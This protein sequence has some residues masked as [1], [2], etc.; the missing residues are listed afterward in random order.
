MRR[1]LLKENISMEYRWEVWP[2]QEC[3]WR[4]PPSVLNVDS[5]EVHVWRIHLDLPTMQ[6][7]QMEQMLSSDEKLR[8]D[9]FQFKW[10]RRRYIASH[11]ALRRILSR[12]LRSEPDQLKFAYS[13]LGK[14]ALASNGNAKPLCFNLSHSNEIALC[15]VTFNRSIGIDLEYVRPNLDADSMAKSFFSPH[16]YV[17]ISSFHPDYRHEA[18]FDLWTLKEAYLKAT[19]KGIG[20]LEKVEFSMFSG[21]VPIPNINKE[22]TFVKDRWTMLQIIPSQGYTAGLAVEGMESHIQFYNF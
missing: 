19:G 5:D 10:H 16:E 14:P 12:Y 20:G 6:I 8:A 18:F 21:E 17:T 13:L 2:K 3:L 7:R 11:G 22:N 9:R 15:A 1:E 4:S